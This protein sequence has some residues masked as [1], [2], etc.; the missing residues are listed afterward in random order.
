MGSKQKI[1]RGP[2]AGSR[3]AVMDALEVGE[4]C[5]FYGES[6]GT[7]QALQA[8][9]GSA[10]RDGDNMYNQGLTQHGGLLFFEGEMP[11]PVSRVTRVEPPHEK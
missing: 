5:I 4:S 9:I 8:S 11:T 1:L 3:R 6:G 2:R 7:I 10:Y